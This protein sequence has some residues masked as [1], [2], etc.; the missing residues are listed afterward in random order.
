MDKKEFRKCLRQIRGEDESGLYKLVKAYFIPAKQA[1]LKR[2]ED[3]ETADKI[4]IKF[5]IYINANADKLKDIENPDEWVF[6]RID[7]MVNDIKR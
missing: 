6:K 2:V 3:P 1:A 5:F 4:A 7:E